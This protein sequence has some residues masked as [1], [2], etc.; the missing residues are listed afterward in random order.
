MM[1]LPN[2]PLISRKKKEASELRE[3]D[4]PL[5]E[6]SGERPRKG[7]NGRESRRKTEGERDGKRERET[8]AL[9]ILWA[10][11]SGFK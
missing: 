6:R 10:N 5:R 8:M 11:Q 1:G 2:N 3:E 4:D 7:K 9:R